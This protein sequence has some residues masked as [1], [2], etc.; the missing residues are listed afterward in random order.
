MKTSPR[1]SAAALIE[2]VLTGETTPL[3]ARDLWPQSRGDCIIEQAY[4]QLFHFEDD[5][6]IRACA[7][8]YREWQ[9]SQMRK[10]VRQLRD[11]TP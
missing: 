3:V 6:D 4:H 2:S 10:L 9:M 8:K 7:P 5:A 11:K 1:E